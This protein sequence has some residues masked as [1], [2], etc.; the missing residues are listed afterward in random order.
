MRRTPRIKHCNFAL[1]EE[2][3]IV[4]DQ[5]KPRQ[6]VSTSV[7]VQEKTKE[8]ADT[9]TRSID[10]CLA[11]KALDVPS[12][13]VEFFPYMVKICCSLPLCQRF[14]NNSAGE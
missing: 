4:G 7:M 12:L 1:V 3:K 14:L 8:G 10:Q 6:V 13:R 2:T 5:S 11:T 9:S